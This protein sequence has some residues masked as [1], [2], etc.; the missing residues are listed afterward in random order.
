VLEA[1]HYSRLKESFFFF[2]K[3]LSAVKVCDGVVSRKIVE[4]TIFEIF[5]L[6][7]LAKNFDVFCSKKLLICARFPS[8]HGFLF[9]KGQFFSQIAK[10]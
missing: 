3:R 1:K 8:Q 2:F 9:K 6:K 7:K 5:S 10:M 4:V